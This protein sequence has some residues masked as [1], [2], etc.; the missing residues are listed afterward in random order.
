[1]DYIVGGI[2]KEGMSEREKTN[3]Q[4]DRPVEF[5]RGTFSK[6]TPAYAY[7]RSVCT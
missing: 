1:L 6:Y 5:S 3:M 2:Q 7:R 4:M